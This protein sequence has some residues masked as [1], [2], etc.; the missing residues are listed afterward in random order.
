MGQ[1]GEAGAIAGEGGARSDESSREACGGRG[2]SGT[3]PGGGVRASSTQWAPSTTPWAWQTATF[4]ACG[5]VF[6]AI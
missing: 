1:L 2:G 3:R 4:L 5:V 6:R